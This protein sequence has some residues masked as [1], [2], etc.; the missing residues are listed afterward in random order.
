MVP[1]QNYLHISFVF[2]LL[3]CHFKVAGNGL[4]VYS[5]GFNGFLKFLPIFGFVGF[6]H[7]G[8][9]NWQKV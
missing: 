3:D 8:D 2:F 6:Y 9:L 4:V 1:S 5:G 7:Y